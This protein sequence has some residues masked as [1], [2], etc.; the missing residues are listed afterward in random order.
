M[1]ICF[2]LIDSIE[3]IAVIN[4]SPKITIK[5]NIH[6]HI[7]T[8]VHTHTLYNQH[9]YILYVLYES[10]FSFGYDCIVAKS[11]F[12]KKNLWAV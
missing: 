6:T 8:H 4:H 11:L 2:V 5:P 1:C 7:H 12:K 9:T 3:M 10:H